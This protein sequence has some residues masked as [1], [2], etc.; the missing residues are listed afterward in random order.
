MEFAELVC[1]SHYSFLHGASHPAEL[2]ERAHALGYR[3]LAI[4]DEASVAGVVQAHMAA[5]PLGIELLIGAQFLC[6]ELAGRI[7][8]IATSRKGYA[9]LGQLITQTRR[10]EIKGQ[11]RLLTEDL[12]S[13]LPDCLAIWLGDPRQSQSQ[14]YQA[15]QRLKALFADR[16]YI[17]CALLLGGHDAAWRDHLQTLAALYRVG[18]VATSDVVMHRRSRK[19][20]ADT[21]TAIRHGLP[22]AACGKRFTPNAEQHLRSRLRLARLY[23]PELMASSIAIVERCNF[24]LDEL[25]Y[26]YPEEIVP[27]GLTPT[28]WLRHLTEEG[29]RRRFP[30]GISP[31]VRQQ[32]E[33][34]LQLIHELH[35][36]P[37]FLTVYDIVAFARSKGI[38]CQGRGSAA[39]SAVCYCLGITEVDPAR[40]SMLF[41]RFISKERNEPPDIDVDFEHQRREE[42]IQYIYQKY[43]RERAALAA[44]VTTYKPRSALRDTGKALGLHA[45]LVDHVAK[46]HQWWDG[47]K[48]DANVLA[49]HLKEALDSPA[50]L[51]HRHEMSLPSPAQCIRWAALCNQLIGAPRHLSQHV[52][53]FVIARH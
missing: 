8:I 33:H 50:L 41:E 43:G 27:P 48:V 9:Q 25:R 49:D 32:I 14:H 40:M 51:P 47:R 15:I 24:S 38:L 36:E 4:T 29:S 11:Y 6:A 16:L 19:P 35:Y 39:N 3:A 10:R 21:L 7:V 2:I 1:R 20:L 23:P 44:S 46:H 17:G 37:Y 18:I 30:N 45:L 42:I 53:G 12:S 26:E 31:K 52:G 28:Q 34:E 5:K 22:I 13:G